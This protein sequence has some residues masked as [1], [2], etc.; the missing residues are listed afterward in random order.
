[1]T[2]ITLPEVMPA[3]RQLVFLRLLPHLCRPIIMALVME[4]KP[5]RV[6]SD[7]ISVIML[8]KVPHIRRQLPIS[9][10]SRLYAWL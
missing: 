5:C 1:M 4:G 7:P 9:V 3:H 8:T 2:V 6:S 10:Y